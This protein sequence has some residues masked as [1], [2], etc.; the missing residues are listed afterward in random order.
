MSARALIAAGA[1]VDAGAANGQTPLVLAAFSGHTSTARA[2]IEAGADVHAHAAGYTALH[3]ATLRGDLPTVEA[4]LAAGANPN[5]P[6]TRG[7]PVRRFRSQWAF[8]TP[9]TGGTALLVA[10]DVP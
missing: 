1:E 9:M 3:A 7:S 2:L 6:L 5:A 8:T 10:A 4:L